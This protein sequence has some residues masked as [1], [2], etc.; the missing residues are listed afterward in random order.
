MTDPEVPFSEAQ[1]VYDKVEDLVR[2]HLKAKTG[3]PDVEFTTTYAYMAGP[4][5]T[6]RIMVFFT[7]GAGF[8][9]RFVVRFPSTLAY[10]HLD[11][12]DIRLQLT[13]EE[14][15]A[16]TDLV[17]LGCCAGFW[18]VDGLVSAT[19]YMLSGAA[20][21]DHALGR[22]VEPKP[23]DT[24]ALLT[25]FG[26]GALEEMW[27][28]RRSVIERGWFLWQARYQEQRASDQP[29]VFSADDGTPDY[30]K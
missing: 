10:A 3:E 16:F 26:G 19:G 14:V 30:L 24:I 20:M 15:E 12:Y 5:E 7:D 27:P 17:W 18:H 21:W 1:R 29:D 9:H 22:V 23:V 6:R 13:A 2:E 25:A 8:V 4:L 28:R 11:A